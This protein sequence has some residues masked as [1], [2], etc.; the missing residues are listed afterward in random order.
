MFTRRLLFGSMLLLHAAIALLGNAGLH[1]ALGCYHDHGGSQKCSHS[2]AAAKH[3][4]CRCQHSQ[5]SG[6][7]TPAHEQHPPIAPPLSDDDCAICQFFA[8]PVEATVGF[9]WTI[10][11]EWVAV[12]TIEVA[13]QPGMLTTSVY[14]V[15]GPPVVA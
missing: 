5:A 15:R 12:A 14:E 4:H 3:S 9:E 1:G 10:E 11:F 2:H 8:R 13:L 6:P 7:S